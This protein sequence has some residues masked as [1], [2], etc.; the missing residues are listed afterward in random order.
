MSNELSTIY[1]VRL[2]IEKLNALC[3]GTLKYARPVQEEIGTVAAVAFTTLETSNDAMGESMMKSRKS[4]L[5]PAVKEAGND[6]KTRWSE[7]KRNVNTA[8]EGLDPVKKESGRL[9][10]L[11]LEPCWKA[12]SKPVNVQ[13]SLYIEL[14]DIYK[15]NKGGVQEH[16]ITIGIDGMLNDL[17]SVN[18]NYQTLSEE[19]ASQDANGGPSASSLKATVVENYNDFCDA[20]EQAVKHIPSE[21]LTQLFNQIDGLRREYAHFAIYKEQPE[22]E[23]TNSVPAK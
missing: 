8:L 17:E 9:L 14:F 16:A 22:E 1:T 3:H 5:T 2:S 12:N 23:E 7:I 11:F 18:L 20:I 19:R 10:K 4:D 13:T 21:A 6:R 15:T